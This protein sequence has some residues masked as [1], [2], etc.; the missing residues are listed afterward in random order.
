MTL[1]TSDDHRVVIVTGAGS[2]IGRATARLFAERGARVVVADLDFEAAQRVSNEIKTEAVPVRVDTSDQDSV[3]SMVQS[4]LDAFGR[5]DAAVNNAGIGSGGAFKVADLP[6]EK[7]RRVM[8]VNL[9]GVFHCLQAEI[10]AMLEGGG[11][12]IVNVASVMGLVANRNSAGYVASKHGVIGLTKAAALDYAKSGVRVN[13]V[14]PG[15][16]DT[17]LLAPTSQEYVD[18]VRAAHPL[19]RLGTADEIA[20]IVAFLAS[21]ES[22]FVTGASYTGDGG[23][24]TK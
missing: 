22:S 11:G 9:D 15:Y 19:G 14:C 13:V 6:L 16:I 20:A 8:S 18:S 24:T 21:P 7:W 4:T 3:N 10:P 12:S 5:L 2:G 17:P 1:H 23:Y